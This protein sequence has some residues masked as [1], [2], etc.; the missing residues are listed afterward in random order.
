MK[1]LILTFS[2]RVFVVVC[3]ATAVAVLL[4]PRLGQPWLSSGN[5]GYQTEAAE[6]SMSPEMVVDKK[7]LAETYGKLP[8]SF[9]PNLG[10]TDDAVRYLARGQG[11]SLFLSQRHATLSLQRS[12]KSGKIESA[13]A[14]RMT[15]DGGSETAV[16][17]GENRGEGRSNYFIGNDPENWRTD[18]PNYGRVKYSSVYD[19]VDLVYYG[20]GQQLEYDFVVHPGMDPGQIKLRFEGV[21][22]AKIDEA[23]GDLLLETGSG[24]L[25]QL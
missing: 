12:G 24:T 6:L 7:A 23:S 3:A 22:S 4:V 5:E 9:E 16:I 11:Y 10:Q 17:A 1:R 2:F 18:I 20:N 8:M 19:G 13:S 14:V 25:R 21:E 15:I